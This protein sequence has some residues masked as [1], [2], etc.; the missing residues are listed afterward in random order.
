M[1][2]DRRSNLMFS[3]SHEIAPR[4]P[5]LSAYNTFYKVAALRFCISAG[6]AMTR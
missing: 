6:L 3:N 5:H 2:W 4:G 1:K